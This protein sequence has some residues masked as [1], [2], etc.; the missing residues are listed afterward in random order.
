MRTYRLC[1]FDDR[2]VRGLLD[3]QASNDGRAAETAEIL[4]QACSDCCEAWAI[5]RGNVFISCG[6]VKLRAWFQASDLSEQRQEIIVAHEDAILNSKWAIASSKHL[7]A[8]LDRLKA[9]RN[10]ASGHS[11][12][13]LRTKLHSSTC[14]I[15]NLR[16]DRTANQIR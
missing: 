4:F 16:Y 6:P 13:A 2:A 3:F 7:L 1:F 10:D 14:A 8:E 9:S 12:L 11:E 5:W 15:N